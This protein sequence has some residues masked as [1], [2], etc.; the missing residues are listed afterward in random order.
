MV[1][2]IVIDK[3]DTRGTLLIMANPLLFQFYK[4]FNELLV[5]DFQPPQT[6]G[7]TRTLSRLAQRAVA[8][9]EVV[10]GPHGNVEQG[11]F[12]AFYNPEWA[13]GVNADV[14]GDMV[15]RIGWI[16][17]VALATTTTELTIAIDGGRLT[18]D[19]T[20]YEVEVELER[21]ARLLAART[22]VTNATQ[23]FFED[24]ASA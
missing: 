7:Q 24:A 4:P 8:K 14:Y 15:G 19:G 10:I 1:G 11:R 22:A 21:D 17:T 12:N 13:P 23:A 16:D 3:Y 2:G 20:T 5:G 6:P 18:L 9:G